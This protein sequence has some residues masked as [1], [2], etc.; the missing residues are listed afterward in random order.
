MWEK[1]ATS[2]MEIDNFSEEVAPELRPEWW[3][4]AKHAHNWEKNIR[5]RK[6][7]KCKCPEAGRSLACSKNRDKT[8][9]TET[10]NDEESDRAWSWR[11][12]Y[13]S[14]LILFV[15][16]THWSGLSGSAIV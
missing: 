7:S 6:N 14:L 15:I 13:G 8:R 3:E 11:E 5:G 1:A 10:V 2:A 12:N 16:V 9:V 4:G